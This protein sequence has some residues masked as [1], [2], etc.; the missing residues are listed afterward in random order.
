[1]IYC[2]GFESKLDKD[3]ECTEGWICASCAQS[4]A[5]GGYHLLDRHVKSW[6]SKERGSGHFLCGI[7]N[8]FDKPSGATTVMQLSIAMP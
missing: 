3:S 4:D 7:I 2:A 1:M 6:R 8:A 5:C